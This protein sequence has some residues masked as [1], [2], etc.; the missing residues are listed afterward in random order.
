MAG[1]H[2]QALKFAYLSNRKLQHTIFPNE[3]GTQANCAVE[4]DEDRRES[5][6]F[7]K[8]FLGEHV[9]GLC[10]H[11]WAQIWIEHAALFP[12]ALKSII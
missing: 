3:T 2:L 6:A 1:Y 5:P 7:G 4:T 10:F 12:S 9:V 11:G 8:F